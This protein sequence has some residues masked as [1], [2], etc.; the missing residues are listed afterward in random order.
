MTGGPTALVF[1][2]G[3]S[4]SKRMWWTVLIG[5]VVTILLGVIILI[6]GVATDSGYLKVV[7]FICGPICI[8]ASFLHIVPLCS[9]Y[10]RTFNKV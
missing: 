9:D 3:G 2:G 4:M 10:K 8:A 6:N 7:S 5:A 1:K